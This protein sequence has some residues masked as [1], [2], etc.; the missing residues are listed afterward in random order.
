MQ[1]TTWFVL[2][3]I[4]DFTTSKTKLAQLAVT[5]TITKTHGTIVVTHV[6]LIVEIVQ[7]HMIQAAQI[8]DR[9]STS[10]LISPEA[11]V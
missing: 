2:P 11:I 4:M 8:V 7:A 1:T 3:V 9:I 6:H 10:L 5:N